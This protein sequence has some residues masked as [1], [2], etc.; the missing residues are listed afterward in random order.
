MLDSWRLLK[1]L[2]KVLFAVAILLT[3]AAK[4]DLIVTGTGTASDGDVRNLW[5]HAYDHIDCQP[6]VD[7]E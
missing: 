7:R 5:K 2:A 3:S 1:G 6:N 4:A